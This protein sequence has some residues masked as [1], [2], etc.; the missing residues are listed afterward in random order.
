MLLL[1]IP[2]YMLLGVAFFFTSARI[3]QPT[4]IEGRVFWENTAT[5]AANVY[6][7]IT[8][9]EEE[10]MTDKNGNF[11][12]RTWKKLPADLIIKY[13]DNKPF[14]VNIKDG[15]KKHTIWLKRP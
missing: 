2:K 12:I 9:G 4:I 7:C 5:P 14:K 15:S 6:V 3:N 13:N 11:S 1:T 10:D 8:E